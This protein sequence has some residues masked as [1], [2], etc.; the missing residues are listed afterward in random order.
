M[1]SPVEQRYKMKTLNLKTALLVTLVCLSQT[2]L[3]Q[4]VPATAAEYQQNSQQWI[5]QRTAQIKTLDSGIQIKPASKAMIDQAVQNLGGR[6]TVEFDKNQKVKL[7]SRT[8]RQ[9]GV[10]VGS[11]A[12]S[13]VATSSADQAG[14]VVVQ[15]PI[16]PNTSITVVGRWGAQQDHLE[17]CAVGYETNQ[18]GQIKL[19]AGSD[20]FQPLNRCA[21]LNQPL[22]V[23]AGYYKVYF[24]KSSWG[25]EVNQVSFVTHVAVGENKVIPLR[26]ISVPRVSGNAAR[27]VK[28]FVQADVKARSELRKS[29]LDLF[30]LISDAMIEHAIPNDPLKKRFQEIENPEE[31]AELCLE[32]GVYDSSMICKFLQ[33]SNSPIENSAQDFNYASAGTF[34][35]VFPGTYT[36]RWNIDEQYDVTE[37]IVVD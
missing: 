26:E 17:I 24:H 15:A 31:F 13:V 37:G 29:K 30:Y 21:K 33:K 16:H 28:Y 32:V 34:V 9:S 3:A 19:K 25:H 5:A 6:A 23:R 36:I 22:R 8:T 14:Q 10:H 11:G 1:E 2:S 27:Q 7:D 18:Q 20:F 4:T 35:S 12:N